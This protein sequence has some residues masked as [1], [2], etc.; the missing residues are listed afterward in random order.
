VAVAFLTHLAARDTA[1]FSV[2]ERKQFI[3]RRLVA[4]A[5]GGEQL[6]D[7]VSQSAANS[8]IRGRFFFNPS[9]S[10]V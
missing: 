9:L 10:E 5:P 7:V 1:Q 4:C 3:E 8:N 2:D 6:G